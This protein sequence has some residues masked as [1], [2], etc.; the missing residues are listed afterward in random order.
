MILSVWKLNYTVHENWV[1]SIQNVMYSIQNI[2]NYMLG[3]TYIFGPSMGFNLWN[4]KLFLNSVLYN[5][6]NWIC[7]MRNSDLLLLASYYSIALDEGNRLDHCARDKQTFWW[8][9]N[10]S[11]RLYVVYRSCACCRLI[12]MH[13]TMTKYWFT[14]A[15]DEYCDRESHA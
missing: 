3:L 1:G 4:P 6:F 2:Q 14:L 12:C 9:N 7:V 5:K 13:H 11:G 15:D 10:K 8:F